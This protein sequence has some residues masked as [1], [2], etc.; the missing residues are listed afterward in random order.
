MLPS[1]GADE[2]ER[3]ADEAAAIAASRRT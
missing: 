3:A 2:M 1:A